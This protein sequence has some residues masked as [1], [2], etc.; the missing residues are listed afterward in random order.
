MNSFYTRNLVAS[1][2]TEGLVQHKIKRNFK[3]GGID[4]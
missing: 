1:K 4:R 2:T 3:K